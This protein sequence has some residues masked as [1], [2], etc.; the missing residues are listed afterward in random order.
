M[1]GLI[2][3]QERNKT[4]KVLWKKYLANQISSVIFQLL[5]LVH[6]LFIQCSVSAWLMSRKRS[7]CQKNE[8]LT[9]L[10]RR[11]FPSWLSAR[12]K[13][14]LS[15]LWTRKST[16]TRFCPDSTKSYMIQGYSMSNKCVAPLF[17]FILFVSERQE[18]TNRWVRNQ[19][20]KM[21]TIHIYYLNEAYFW[22]LLWSDVRVVSS[23]SCCFSFVVSS[24]NIC[25]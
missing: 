12:Q 2:T 7:L 9:V 24:H 18:H 25:D 21:S 10:N 15:K 6:N 1:V 19:C 4:S 8:G 13:Y 11:L 14:F 16:Q 17:I 23:S 5:N 22:Q 20:W 3:P